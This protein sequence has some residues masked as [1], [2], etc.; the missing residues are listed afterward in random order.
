MKKKSILFTCIF[1]IVSLFAYSQNISVKSFEVLPNDQTARVHEPVMDQNGEKCALIK[2]V[3][4]ET[5]FAWEG[6]TLGIT[7]VKKKVSEYWVYVPR[8][9]KKI[10]I[11]HEE[12][13]VLRNYVYPE[14]IKEATV[15]EMVLTTAKVKTVVEEPEISSAYLVIKSSPEKAD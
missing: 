9:S 2:V 11:K 7:E 13:G 5:G 10:T 3:T 4:T 1:L 14:A 12:M 6:G 15:Y 8:G